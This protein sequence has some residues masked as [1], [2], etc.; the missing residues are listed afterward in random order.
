MS[1]LSQVITG[2]NF[3]CTAAA[4]GTRHGIRLILTNATT[5]SEEGLVNLVKLLVLRQCKSQLILHKGG[6]QSFSP[7][8]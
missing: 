7:W 6:G 5:Y 8:L 1:G 3:N 2:V 4:Q